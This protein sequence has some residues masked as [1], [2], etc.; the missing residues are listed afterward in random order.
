V[1][2]PRHCPKFAEFKYELSCSECGEF[3]GGRH[4]RSKTVKFPHRYRSNCCG[5]ELQSE[6]V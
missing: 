2:A 5:A 1:D 6:R 3:A 4:K